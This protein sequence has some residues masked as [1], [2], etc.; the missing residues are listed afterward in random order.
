M[1]DL[2]PVE[3]Q[4]LLRLSRKILSSFER[5]AYEPVSVPPFEYA[6]VLEQDM[7]P[8]DPGQVLR[9]VEPETGEIVALRPDMTPQIARL[10]ATRLSDAPP[11]LR[12][13]YEGDVVRR[14]V[15]RAR[16]DR[17]IH[18]AGF[19]LVG[20]G[21][22]AGDLEVLTVAA[23][24]VRA[25]G[26]TNFTLDLGHAMIAGALVRTA[27][28]DARASIVE[29]LAA[30]DG[31][32]TRR[33]AEH[34]GIR[35][36]DLEAL[37]A[38]PGLCGGADVWPRA[39]RVLE[40][41]PAEP[42]LRELRAL[43]DAVDAAGLAPRL[44]AD[45]GET[46]SFAYYTGML[47]QVLADG[48]GEPV[49]GGGRYDR[50]FDR[51]G[52]PRPAAGFAIDLG[53]LGWA[54][55]RSGQS[56]PRSARVLLV[57]GAADAAAADAALSEL[58]RQG[59]ACARGPESGAAAY[60]ARWRYSHTLEISGGTATLVDVGDGTVHPIAAASPRE[61]AACVLALIGPLVGDSEKP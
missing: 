40:G 20:L 50:L 60:A 57:R 22:P 38:L 2:L 27:R 45:L 14:R 17:Q 13:C 12:L 34:A 56:M 24:A 32:E 47:F 52:A 26:L 36:R 8:L 9:F 25:S 16:R 35:G 23:S 46:W 19:E 5:F 30:K 58:R 53:N 37:V 54:L 55:E 28:P 29:A 43:F 33:R 11:P 15:E 39:E 1:R 10:V 21:G 59:V 3:A 42:P 6:E 61:A 7:G 44:V 4:R 51:F 48:P 31:E 49:G 18:Q 41:T